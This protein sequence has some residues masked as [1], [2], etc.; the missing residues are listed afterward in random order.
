MFIGP[1]FFLVVVLPCE[2]FTVDLP[3]KW[4]VKG[5]W[6]E[7]RRTRRRDRRTHQDDPVLGI[8]G[9]SART[10]PHTIGLP[11]LHPDATSRLSFIRQAQTAGFTLRQIG[12]ILDTSDGGAAPCEHVTGAVS[13]RLA[14]IDARIVELQATRTRLQHLARRAK[15]QDPAACEG[16]CSIIA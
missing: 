9:P 2:T 14:E 6:H 4:K 7:D 3:V 16:I 11:Q 12:Q 5:E 8:R 10:G 15:T 13:A 1:G